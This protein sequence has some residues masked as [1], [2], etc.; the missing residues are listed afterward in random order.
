MASDITPDNIDGTYPIAG[1]DNDSQGFRTNFVNTSNNFAFAKA[2]IEDLQS[3]A[4]L[5]APLDGES[6]TDNDMLGEQIRSAQLLDARETIFAH[7]SFAGSFGLDHLNGH[8]QTITTTGA[9]TIG[10]FDNWPGTGG[11][12]VLGRVRLEVTVADVS[13]TLT[14]PSSVT[15]GTAAIRGYDTNVIT[16]DSTGTFI[17]EFTSYDSVTWAIEDKSRPAYIPPATATTAELADITATVNTS[18]LKVAGYMVF[19]TDTGAPV[20]ATGDADADVWNDATGSTA[21]TP[22]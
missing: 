2:E 3:K 19:N 6:A 18:F 8:Y 20:W 7:G 5:K 13:H 11:L 21:H 12:P 4:V 17:F 22:V 15:I 10:S 14:L 1:I 9:I 16:F